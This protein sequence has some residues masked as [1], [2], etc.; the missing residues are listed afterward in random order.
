VRRHFSTRRIARYRAGCLNDRQTARAREHLVKCARCGDAAAS[1]ASVSAILHAV[2]MPPMPDHVSARISSALAA[3]Q[4]SRVAVPGRPGVPERSRLRWLELAPGLTSPRALRALATAGAAA[5]LVIIAAGGYLAASR[6]SGPTALPASGTVAPDH[7]VTM[8]YQR[9]AVTQTTTAVASGTDFRPLRLATQVRA[10]LRAYQPG[11]ISW[12]PGQIPSRPDPPAAASGLPT[13]VGKIGR[14]SIADLEG[15]AGLIGEGRQVLLVDVARYRAA[16]AEI[17]VTWPHPGA[18]MF[19]IDVAGRSCSIVRKQLIATASL[20]S[21]LG[22]PDPG[23]TRS[24]A[25]SGRNVQT[26]S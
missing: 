11:L 6:A 7:P 21:R 22:S 3:E 5:A 17:I 18:S 23:T 25:D 2:T 1:L 26:S 19:R 9:D 12:S 14:M 4:A 24:T 8:P 15:C 20:S 16:P 13:D 10:D